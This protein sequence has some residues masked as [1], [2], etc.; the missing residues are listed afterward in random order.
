MTPNETGSIILL[1]PGSKTPVNLDYLNKELGN[2]LITFRD[3]DRDALNQFIQ[4]NEAMSEGAGFNMDQLNGISQ[5]LSEMYQQN[6][7]NLREAD[8]NMQKLINETNINSMQPSVYK[9]DNQDLNDVCSWANKS[10][11]QTPA[12][13]VTPIETSFTKGVKITSMR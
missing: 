11:S 1:R 12:S 6:M 4:E 5:E 9:G 10:A 7:N 8:R 2:N 13:T 3:E